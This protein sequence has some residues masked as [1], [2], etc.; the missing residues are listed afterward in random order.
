ML[1]K[2]YKKKFFLRPPG[3]DFFFDI[4]SDGNKQF[5]FLGLH[6]ERRYLCSLPESPKTQDISFF[7]FVTIFLFWLILA[8]WITNQKLDD[9][10]IV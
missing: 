2:K 8:L 4:R 3:Q 5:F 10:G 6:K 9:L 1:R 7:I